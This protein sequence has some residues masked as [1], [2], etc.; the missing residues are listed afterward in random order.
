MEEF[1]NILKDAVRVLRRPERKGEDP[2]LKAFDMAYN[3]ALD[4]VV[5]Q[6]IER[7]PN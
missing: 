6:V 3:K 7:I 2:I 5:K 4:D 1:K